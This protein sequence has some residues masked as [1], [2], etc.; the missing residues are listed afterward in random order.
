[1]MQF[2]SCNHKQKTTSS[3]T[4]LWRIQ[5]GQF[6]HAPLR[7]VNYGTCPPPAGKKILHGLV[8]IGHLSIHIE[9]ELLKL[10]IKAVNKAVVTRSFLGDKMVKNALEALP[11]FSS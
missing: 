11:N 3:S 10:S 2:G 6:G 5:R 9:I 8:G 4:G 1:M 7:S